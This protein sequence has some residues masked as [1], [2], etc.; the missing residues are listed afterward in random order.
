MHLLLGDFTG[1]GL[2]AAIG[3]MPLADVFYRMT[4][5]GHSLVEILHESNAKLRRI[6]PRGVFCCAPLLNIS[7]RRRTVDFWGGG[8]PAGYVLR[9]GSAER[10]PLVSRHLPLGVL[11]PDSFRDDYES[12]SL[13]LGDRVFLL[14]DGVLEAQNERDELFG[15]QRL[16]EVLDAGHDAS[17][18]FDD[19]QP[20]SYTHLTLPTKRIV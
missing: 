13:E 1:H 7:F 9:Q 12:Y 10:V 19:I 11:D 5:K 15:E 2:P 17:L 4:G 3:A 18:L 6:L 16:L 14:S 20:V 8:L